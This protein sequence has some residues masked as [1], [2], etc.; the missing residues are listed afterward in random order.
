MTEPAKFSTTSETAVSR[1]VRNARD[2]LVTFHK[3]RKNDVD[4]II[5]KSG[6]V[7]CIFDDPTGMTRQSIE[8]QIRSAEVSN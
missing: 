8:Q 5:D 1:D 3:Q 6:V 2:V 7:I 4:W